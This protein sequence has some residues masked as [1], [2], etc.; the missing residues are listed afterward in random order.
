MIEPGNLIRAIRAI[1]DQEYDKFEGFPK[2]NEEAAERWSEAFFLFAKDISPPSSS[3]VLAKE[4]M[5]ERLMSVNFSENLRALELAVMEFARIASIGMSPN[6]L[7]TPPTVLLD[8]SKT[9]AIGFS[10]GTAKGVAE[11]I[12]SVSYEWFVTGTAINN[13]TSVTIK[14]F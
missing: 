1:S 14:W 3:M 10:G 5:R 4:S 13:S 2:S 8:Y 6:F 9:Y 12:A 7:A 11:A